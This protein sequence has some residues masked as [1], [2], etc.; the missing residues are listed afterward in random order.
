MNYVLNDPKK[1]SV[2]HLQSFGLD[3]SVWWGI[4]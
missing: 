4:S 1:L 2:K 3:L